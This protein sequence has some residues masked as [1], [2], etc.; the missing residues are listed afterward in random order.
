M[1]C[2]HVFENISGGFCGISRFLGNFAGPRP[3]EIS[4]AL[5]SNHAY[6][7]QKH[8]TWNK[9]AAVSLCKYLAIT[10]THLNV[11]TSINMQTLKIIFFKNKEN[12][13]DCST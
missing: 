8:A 4:E 2:R 5:I 11:R 13:S 9:S 6:T 7:L 10:V 12:N 3:R 1:F